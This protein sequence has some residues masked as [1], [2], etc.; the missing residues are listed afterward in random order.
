MYF[1]FNLQLSSQVTI[2]VKALKIR[3]SLNQDSDFYE[4]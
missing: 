2:A 4:G 1:I 3:K